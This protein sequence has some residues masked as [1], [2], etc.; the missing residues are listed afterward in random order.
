M[1]RPTKKSYLR[2]QFDMT[3]EQVDLIDKLK[4]QHDMASRAEVVRRSL[5][6]CDRVSSGPTL[7]QKRGE[8]FIEV[9]FFVI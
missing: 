3:Q 8:E 6:L 9:K 7:Y 2:L 5:K 1:T 4:V